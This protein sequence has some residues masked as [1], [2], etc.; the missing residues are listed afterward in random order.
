V[1]TPFVFWEIGKKFLVYFPY[2]ETRYWEELISYFP[3]TIIL[4]YDRNSRKKALV[5]MHNEVNKTMQ[6]GRLQCRY[7]SLELNTVELASDTMTYKL[8]SMKTDLDIFVILRL[9]LDSLLGCSVGITN[10]KGL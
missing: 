3:F 5:C 10:G 8:C 9:I 2:F 4:V 7:Y 6:F 1:E